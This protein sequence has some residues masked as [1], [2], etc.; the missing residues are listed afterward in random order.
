LK[1]SI[2]VYLVIALPLATGCHEK[3]EL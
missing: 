2:P 3:K 1:L